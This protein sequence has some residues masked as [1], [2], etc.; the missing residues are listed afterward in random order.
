MDQEHNSDQDDTSQPTGES[1]LSAASLVS[2]FVSV[3]P[4]TVHSNDTAAKLHPIQN[5]DTSVCL[6]SFN[7]CTIFLH[8]MI[9]PL[10]KGN[11]G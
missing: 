10:L 7:V 2:P 11:S 9:M 1:Q 3:K 8:G 6:S 4:T 5:T